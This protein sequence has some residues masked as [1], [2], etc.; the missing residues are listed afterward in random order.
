MTT[1]LL[2]DPANPRCVVPGR[3]AAAARL[4]SHLYARRLDEAL[5]SGVSP[6]S[7]AALSLRARTLIGASARV[8]LARSLRCL[9][10]DARRPL[11]PFTAH[12]PICRG[13]IL[14]SSRTI[15]ELADRLAGR[16]P[17]DARGVAQ[18]QLLL[19]D[20][21][22]PVYYRP[23]ADDL[24]PALRQALRGLDLTV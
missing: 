23:G 5:A 7:S 24:E 21:E 10:R 3:A 6:D 2:T 8:G 16:D 11:G 19:T 13:K 15:E 20:G 18:V 9:L 1:L 4:S 17:V 12:V 22:G 14:Q